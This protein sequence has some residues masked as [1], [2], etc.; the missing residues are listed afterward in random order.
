MILLNKSYDRY[1]FEMIK[2]MREGKSAHEKFFSDI[3]LKSIDAIIGFN[4]EYEIFLWNKGAEKMFG[5]EK[6]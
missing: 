4:N 5:W 6:R 2:L 1:I 3:I